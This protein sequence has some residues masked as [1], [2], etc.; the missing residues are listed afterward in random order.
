ML[1]VSHSMEDIAR[2][3]KKVLVMNHGQV[4]MYADTE[5]VFSRAAELS[6]MGLS[7]PA[8]TRVFMMLRERGYEVGG[9]A[10]TVEQACAQLL[11]LL[12]QGGTPHA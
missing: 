3:A 2:I 10:Y 9:N 1:L 12:K 7:V 6:A 5:E 4:A 8:V 11:P